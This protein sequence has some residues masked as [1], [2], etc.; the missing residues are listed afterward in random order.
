MLVHL[1]VMSLQSCHKLLI[2]V[3]NHLSSGSLSTTQAD[4]FLRSSVVFHLL[5]LLAT[6]TFLLSDHLWLAAK[7]L[8][9]LVH[10]LRRLDSLN[11]ML[12]GVVEAD[13]ELRLVERS[14]TNTRWVSR[15]RHEI[16]EAG[17]DARDHSEDVTIE[18]H[19]RLFRS[20]SSSNQHALANVGFKTG[21]AA[22]E[23]RLEN[24]SSNDECSA[25]GAAVKPILS[26]SYESCPNMWMRRSYNGQLYHGTSSGYA[27]MSK[28]HPGD[29]L[30]V[31]VDLDAHTMSFK[32]NGE[33]EGTPGYTMHLR[34]D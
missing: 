5:P 24:D 19:G 20:T 4:A 1:G 3:E 14:L 2:T 21:K 16:A 6:S 29:V 31:E 18:D 32:K 17:F 10:V 30:R 8:P 13:K 15:R 25:L 22:W 26:S 33:D 7:L 23:F 11:A 28:V 9:H 12:P 34:V 27:A